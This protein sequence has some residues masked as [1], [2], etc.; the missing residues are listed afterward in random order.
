MSVGYGMD[1]KSLIFS[2]LM[3]PVWGSAFGSCLG[4]M[5]QIPTE[6]QQ[7][8]HNFIDA[9]L[10]TF[11]EAHRQHSVEEAIFKTFVAGV[12]MPLRRNHEGKTGKAWCFN[13]GDIPEMPTATETSYARRIRCIFHRSGFTAEVSGV[14]SERLVC[15]AKPLAKEWMRSGEAAATLVRHFLM[16]FHAQHSTASCRRIL[17]HPDKSF[18]LHKDS[19]RLVQRMAG[20]TDRATPDEQHVGEPNSG[21]TTYHRDAQGQRAHPESDAPHDVFHAVS[22]LCLECSRL[23]E[24]NYQVRSR[25]EFVHARHGCVEIFCAPCGRASE[26]NEDRGDLRTQKVEFTQ[27]SESPVCPLS[28]TGA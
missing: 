1:G 27:A 24:D 26:K 14:D 4:T 19:Q 3:S 28:M 8:G 22:S 7:Q 21:S 9:A 10:M 17:E 23:H 2:D 6:F 16:P 18:Q 13:V 12:T 20:K 5:L 25:N 15:V 11:D